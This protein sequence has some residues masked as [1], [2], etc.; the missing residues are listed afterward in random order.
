[1]DLDTSTDGL[2]TLEYQSKG[3]PGGRFARKALQM[4]VLDLVP[5]QETFSLIQG[6]F[7]PASS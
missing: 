2:E 6:V 4:L 3:V 7:E 1:M 5:G